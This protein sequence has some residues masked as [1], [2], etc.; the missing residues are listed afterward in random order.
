MVKFNVPINYNGFTKFQTIK[1]IINTLSSVLKYFHVVGI[2][3]T[4]NKK[5]K[6]SVKAHRL[7]LKFIVENDST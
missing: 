7:I 2:L 1:K 5:K 3:F 4:V 6:L